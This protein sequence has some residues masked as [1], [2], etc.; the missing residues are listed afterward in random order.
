MVFAGGPAGDAGPDRFRAEA[1]TDRLISAL[2]EVRPA[3]GR[4]EQ[5]E[6]DG[7]PL[8]LVLV[9]NPAGFR[10]GLA[11]FDAAGVSAMIAINDQYA[12]GRD[13]SWLWDVDFGSLADEGV[14]TVSGT[15]AWDM[16]LRLEHDDVPI[17]RVEE[18]L[19]RALRGFRER[20]MPVDGV[21]RPRRIFCT[22]TAMLALRKELAELT[23]VEDIW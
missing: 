3:F 2:A 12:D 6:L 19:S 15:R 8:E 10:L 5:L 20:T 9:K 16:A 4:G 18:D 23:E 1:T 11:S 14:D 13:M 17:G 7:L 21:G 22:Y